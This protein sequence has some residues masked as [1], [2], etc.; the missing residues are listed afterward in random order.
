MSDRTRSLLFQPWSHG[1]LRLRNRVVM[2]P[3][4]RRKAAPDG[5]L[6][7]AIVA[8]YER[9]A[10]NDVG[11]IVSEGISVDSLHAYDTLTVPRLETPGQVEGWRRV[12]DAVHAAGGA[13]AP[14]LWHTGRL[15]ANPIGPSAATMPPRPDGTA[16]PEVRAMEPDDFRQ[17]LEAY[18]LSARNAIEIGSDALEIHGAHGYLLDSFLS[19]VNNRRTDEHGGSP[20]NRMRFPL[21]VVRAIRTEVGP[22]FP[23]LYRFSQWK[24]DDYREIKFRGPDELERWVVALREAGVDILHVSTRDLLDPAFET[25]PDS[26]AAWSRRLSGL[27]VV[28]VGKVSLFR[29]MDESPPPPEQAV[30]DPEPILAMVEDGEIDLVAVGRALIANPDWVPLV[31]SGR[32]RDLVPYSRELLTE[33]R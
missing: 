4:T 30:A 12:V 15:A 19:P 3:M 27:P 5:I 10:Q 25:S 33:L 16:R 29:G 6:T 32:W 17:V 7:D 8:Y 9:R 21:E 18:R 31:R 20:E 13:F 28:G 24:V 22:D 2:A 14:Q 23:I 26:L 1:T 11:L